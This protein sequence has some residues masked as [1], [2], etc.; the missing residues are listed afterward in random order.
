MKTVLTWL[1]RSV[2]WLGLGFMLFT[3]V[4]T[5]LAEPS[6]APRDVDREKSDRVLE[7]VDGKVELRLQRPEGS[8]IGGLGIIE[9]ASPERQLTPATTGRIVSIPVREG[10]LVEQGALLVELESGLER[11]AL[12]AAEAELASAR[13]ELRRIRGTVRTEDLEVLRRDE[14]AASVRAEQS[15]S[16]YRRLLATQGSG[17]LSDEELE[18]AQRQADQDALAA[19]AATSR[20]KSAEE[21]RPLDVQVAQARVDVAAARRDQAGAN[22]ELKRIVAPLTG[23][24]LEILFQEGEF[25]QPGGVEPVVV[26][27]DTRTLRARIDVDERDVDAVLDSGQAIITVDAMPGRR[28]QGEVVSVA[29]RMGRKNVRSD[30]PTERIDTKILEVVVDLGPV[31]DLIIGQRVMAYLQKRD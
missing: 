14:E 6:T 25:V 27:G 16:S 10:E 9:P 1:K 12:A 21:S 5:A 11:A 18:R 26:M 29:R 15:A 31:S 24:I 22:L 13:L 28:F 7:Q 4:R 8:W 3:I 30:E 23:E 17:G 20:R 19:R 2:L